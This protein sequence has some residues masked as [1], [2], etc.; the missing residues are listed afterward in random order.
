[1]PGSLLR[2]FSFLRVQ[3]MCYIHVH[4]LKAWST[5]ILRYD[6]PTRKMKTNTRAKTK[7]KK[8]QHQRKCGNIN[9][10]KKK[11]KPQSV[12]KEYALYQYQ[13]NFFIFHLYHFL[14][15]RSDGQKEK[16]LSLNYKFRIFDKHLDFVFLCISFRILILSFLRF[17]IV[18]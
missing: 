11:K 13:R 14:F 17:Q 4:K 9:E 3:K 12:R 5:T 8:K 1:M 18:E 16:I 7:K 2:P 15:N 10:F 6:V